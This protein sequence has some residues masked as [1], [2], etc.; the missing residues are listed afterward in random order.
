MHLS[1]VQYQA[2]LMRLIH[3]APAE[4]VVIYS[5]FIHGVR[6]FQK[7]PQKCGKGRPLQKQNKSQLMR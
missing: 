5:S 7:K 3:Q 1:K 4:L 2:L 6:P